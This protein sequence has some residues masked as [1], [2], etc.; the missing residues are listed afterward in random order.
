MQG[1]G[2]TG[3][4]IP[5][6][7]LP[8][9]Y[10]FAGSVEYAPAGVHIAFRLIDAADGA[11]VWSRVFDERTDEEARASEE[12][13][14]RELATTLVQP[15]GIIYAYARR[16]GSAHRDGATR[17][18]G[19]PRY[20]CLLDAIESFRSFDPQQASIAR[21]CLER[22]TS[23]DPTFALGWTYLAPLYLRD[24]LYGAVG[25]AD[26]LPA[27]DRALRAARRGVELNPA[28]ARAHEMLFAV[29]FARR[30]VA[31]AFA[32]GEKAMLLNRYDMRIAGTFGA[33]KIAVGEVDAGM[34]ILREAS[35]DGTVVPTFEQFFLFLGSYLKGD[36]E[37]AS[38]HASQLTSD[39]FQLGLMAR[40]LV[41]CRKGD[42]DAARGAVDR[43]VALNPLW[44]RSV[45]TE[46]GKF[47]Y[48]D[49]IV[50]RLAIDLSATGLSAV[51]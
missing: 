38:F 12:A 29:L 50:D 49:A 18:A 2:E 8:V 51:N 28:S 36:F 24:H 6:L 15:F 46:L 3:H 26:E 22:L 7:S 48:S 35:G 41:A 19:D 9:D 43:L 1:A 45:R 31:A 10:R 21:A 42:H 5:Q 40:A 20:R 14:V 47:F 37:R 17:S 33:R 4:A 30:D 27:L 32:A 34:A 25:R 16:E 23:L 44:R 11:V 13:I 39:T